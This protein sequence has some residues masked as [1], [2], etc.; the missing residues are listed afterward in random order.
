[1]DRLRRACGVVFLLCL[2]SCANS[3]AVYTE[4]GLDAADAVWDAYYRDRLAYCQ[5]RH[6]AG[7]DGAV[8]CFGPTA[9]ADEKVGIAM[10]T[11]VGLLRGY[12]IAR[13]AGDQPSFAR[14]ALQV[15]GLIADLPPEARKIFE[16]VKGIPQ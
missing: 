12:W 4:H 16:R 6:A 10:E 11:A 7:T 9:D 2:A 13:A 14:I 5:Q 3:A 15:N 8:A 1:M